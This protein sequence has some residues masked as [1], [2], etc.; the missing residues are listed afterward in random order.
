MFVCGCVGV[1]VCPG[2]VVIRVFLLIAAHENID[3]DCGISTRTPA[4]T[5][6]PS[7]INPVGK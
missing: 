5:S 6:F 4:L 2:E 1:W 3:H 7:L